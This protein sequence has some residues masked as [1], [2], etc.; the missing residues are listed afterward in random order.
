MLLPLH[1]LQPGP[2]S[3]PTDLTLTRATAVS[4]YLQ[5]TAGFYGGLEQSFILY[6]SS[7]TKAPW[8]ETVQLVRPV[9]TGDTVE[10]KLKD[11]HR[12]LP[13]QS[14][15]V[16]VFAENDIGDAQGQTATYQTLGMYYVIFCLCV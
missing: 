5:W 15:M 11:E 2:P 7:L 16:Q 1:D 8:N 10:H 13:G 9:N 3:A 6:I 14:Y 4:L 12:V